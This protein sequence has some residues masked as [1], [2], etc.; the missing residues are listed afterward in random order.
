MNKK[1][2]NVLNLVNSSLLAVSLVLVVRINFLLQGLDAND[3]PVVNINFGPIPDKNEYILHIFK[4]A[5]G[6]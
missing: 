5:N 4:E 3:E 2:E 1:W 6:G